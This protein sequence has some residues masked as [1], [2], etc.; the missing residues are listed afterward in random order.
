[1]LSEHEAGAHNVERERRSAPSSAGQP[2][3]PLQEPGRG[4][5]PHQRRNNLAALALLAIGVVMLLG[6]L[7]EGA[8][9]APVPPL[10]PLPPMP[11]IPGINFMPGMI[12]LTIAS[13][14]LFFAFWRRFYPLLI[15]GCILAGLS[16]GVTFVDITGGASMPWGL[17]LGFLAIFLLGRELFNI[18]GSWPIFPAVPLFGVGVILALGNL[19][20]FFPL[21][22]GLIWLPLLL[23]GA[24]LY[25][26]RNRTTR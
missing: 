17:S 9:A 15:L 22:N 24:G 12:L 25:L 21:A 8:G 18:R 2:T 10:P 13:C 20:S 3:R 16:L 26:G 6:R 4:V 19:P 11:P 5:H 14:F 7:L 1:M 23:I